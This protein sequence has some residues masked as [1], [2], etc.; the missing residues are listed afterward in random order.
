MRALNDFFTIFKVQTSYKPRVLHVNRGGEFLNHLSDVKL[1]KRGIILEVIALDTLAQNRPAERARAIIIE[2]TYCIIDS[3]GIP[4]TLWLYA[5]RTAI[6]ILNLLPALA[7]G[8]K[9]P[10]ECLSA[11][12]ELG[13]SKP[14]IYHL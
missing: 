7:N 8:G 9:S 12:I 6:T 5:I 2:D 4:Y 10:Y 1:G 11:F 13:G 3:S 14:Y